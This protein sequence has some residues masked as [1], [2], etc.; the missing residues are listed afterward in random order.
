MNFNVLCVMKWAIIFAFV[1]CCCSNVNKQPDSD[2]NIENK[3]SVLQINHSF[4]DSN[5][6]TIE[7]R[8]NVPDSFFRES[9]DSNSF[10]FYLRNLPLK[11]PGSSVLYFDGSVKSNHN[12]YAAVVDMPISNKDLQQ[13]A[14][15]VMRLRAEYLFEQKKYSSISF[16][17]LGDGKMHPYTDYTTNTNSYK[18]FLKYMDH[19]FNYANTASLFKQLKTKSIVDIAPGDVFIQKGNPYGHAVMVVDVC[20]D[21]KGNKKFM[22]AQSYMPAQE[23]QILWNPNKRNS[24]WYDVTDETNLSTPE[25]SFTT[26]DLKTW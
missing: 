13:C 21:K 8:F 15:A 7:S 18:T 19:V 6:N 9:S 12:V 1:I 5:S 11:P 22:L 26:N 23:T 20:K 25:W 16:R 4:Q 17:F 14:D 24:V 2:K 3:R 10:A